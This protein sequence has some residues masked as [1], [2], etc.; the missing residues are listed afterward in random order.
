MSSCV[1]DIVP[2]CYVFVLCPC[3]CTVLSLMPTV[4]R[5]NHVVLI[6][7]VVFNCGYICMFCLIVMSSAMIMLLKVS[8]TWSSCLPSYTCI[9]WY[10]LTNL[11]QIHDQTH[12]TRPWPLFVYCEACAVLIF[13]Y[14]DWC[15]QSL[16]YTKYTQ[17]CINSREPK[18][19]H[20]NILIKSDEQGDA[21]SRVFLK[22]YWY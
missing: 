6:V 10:I 11:Y 21:M 14:Q 3:H 7:C 22:K 15:I 8:V 16:T 5:I 19:F 20:K 4:W 1:C 18:V 9:L 2:I 13:K 12:S 17:I